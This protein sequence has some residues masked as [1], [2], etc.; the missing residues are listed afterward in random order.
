MVYRQVLES[1]CA[2]SG[3]ERAKKQPR[4]SGAGDV[5]GALAQK[6]VNDLLRPEVEGPVASVIVTSGGRC[7]LD[8]VVVRRVGLQY[9]VAAAGVQSDLKP[10][11]R[12]DTEAD[13]TKT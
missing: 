7:N 13:R 12:A 2:A 10:D 1:R 4:R 9:R 5:M 6:V 11:R 3:S 8:V